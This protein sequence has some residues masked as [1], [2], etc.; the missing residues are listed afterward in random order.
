[1]GALCFLYVSWYDISISFS[2]FTVISFGPTSSD[3]PST[4]SFVSWSLSL[5]TLDT[6]H[7]HLLTFLNEKKATIS[8]NLAKALIWKKQKAIR[9][10]SKK[11]KNQQRP[12][13]EN[14]YYT[15]VKLQIWTSAQLL[16]THH[17]AL[18]YT[19]SLDIYITA[20]RPLFHALCIFPSLHPST[21]YRN[22][23][24]PRLCLSSF[25]SSVTWN[26]IN[27]PF[28]E[29]SS[30]SYPCSYSAIL[31]VF[32]HRTASNRHRSHQVP[33]LALSI[34]E[35]FSFWY[36]DSVCHHRFTALSLERRA[37]CRAVL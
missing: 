28:I 36:T 7:N 18:L 26:R 14:D 9:K 12:L 5:Q 34:G 11:D 17:H 19:L 3:P 24:F 10:Q 1:M 31:V 2:N 32:T 6:Y 4:L 8:F 16:E 15:Q 22:P 25:G 20:K 21:C 33:H 27:R 23:A 30:T 37:F 13:E 35:L 29:S